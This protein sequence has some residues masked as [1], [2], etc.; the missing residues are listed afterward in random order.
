M[1][2][3]GCD[4]GTQRSDSGD[5]KVT[6][7]P[8]N[9]S[10]QTVAISRETSASHQGRTNGRSTASKSTIA[11]ISVHVPARSMNGF[12]AGLEAFQMVEFDLVSASSG[13][14]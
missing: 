4:E 10:D 7:P 9:A 3:S 13:R 6:R 1:G 8:A 2:R 11:M 14:S 12:K 5:A